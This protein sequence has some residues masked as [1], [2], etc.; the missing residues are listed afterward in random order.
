VA[1]QCDYAKGNRFYELEH[2][3]AMPR[4]RLFGN[5]LLSL[6]N[7]FASG[8][9]D[10]MDPTN[11]FT[12]IHRKALAA[13]PLDKLD[14]GYFF[15]SDM[16]FRLYTIRAVVR[17]VAMP[18]LR[19]RGEQSAGEPRGILLSRKV[20]LAAIKRIFY[21]YFLRRLQRGYVT[22]LLRGR[23]YRRRNRIRDNAL[24][25]LGDYRRSNDVRCSDA[26]GAAGNHRDTIAAWSAQLR[27][28][29]HS[30]RAA[31]TD[32]DPIASHAAKSRPRPAVGSFGLM[33]EIRHLVCP[34]CDSR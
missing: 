9:W 1:G 31:A 29:E 10:V 17:D 26:G 13:L 7:K 30:T 32:D 6:V 24:D 27:R 25:S 19:R 21:T 12:A 3:R 14:R 18:A 4:L 15:E 22:A 2:L 11:G 8:Y 5:S 23:D 20:C 16:L 33:P 34:V 28:S